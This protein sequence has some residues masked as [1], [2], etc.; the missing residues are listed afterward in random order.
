MGIAQGS[1]GGFLPIPSTDET[2]AQLANQA[3]IDALKT[4]LAEKEK[5]VTALRSAISVLEGGILVGGSV[6]G[7]QE[8]ADIGIVAAA[9]RW[10]RETGKPQTT[11][12]I[13]DALIRR[14]WT[15]TSKNPTATIYATLD[16][17]SDFIRDKRTGTWEIK[18]PK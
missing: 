5:E 14:G 9:K 13:K 7:T 6:T 3:T 12:E 1:T 2:E 18:Q 15:T 17:S 10:L 11:S 4:E 8:Y 16:N